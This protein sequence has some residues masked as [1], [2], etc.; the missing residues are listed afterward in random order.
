MIH[1]EVLRW[2]GAVWSVWLLLRAH[3][4]ED[5]WNTLNAMGVFDGPSYTLRLVDGV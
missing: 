2:D 5:A 3:D 4:F 1:F